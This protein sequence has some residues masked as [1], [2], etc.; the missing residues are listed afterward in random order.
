MNG[1]SSS[2]RLRGLEFEIVSA[3]AKLEAARAEE[4]NDARGFVR[5]S[6]RAMSAQRSALRAETAGDL[7]EHTRDVDGSASA[8]P[9]EPLTGG[10]G[11]GPDGSVDPGRCSS[12]EEDEGTPSGSEG[13]D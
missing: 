1:G 3:E 4:Q 10:T 9:S 11:P 6:G 12:A 5:A 2:A 8:S 13:E 7:D